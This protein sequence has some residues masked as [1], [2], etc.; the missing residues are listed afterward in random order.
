MIFL[1][2]GKSSP[3]FGKVNVRSISDH[4][5]SRKKVTQQ[6]VLPP[7]S[8][9][10][11]EA[12]PTSWGTRTGGE[13]SGRGRDGMAGG[14][15]STSSA[16]RAKVDEA[17][18][19]EEVVCFRL[20][21]ELWQKIVDEN[22]Q[23]NDLLALAMTCRLFRDTTKVLGRK[24]ETN[25]K[26]NR[27][28]DLQ[29][30]GK[31]ASHTLD[32]FQWVC[33]TFEIL[34]GY[35]SRYG[36]DHNGRVKGAVYEGDLV[37][38]AAFQGS[39]EILRWLVE[40]KGWEPNKHT[41]DRAGMG[42]S[43]KV[44]EYVKGK[45]YELNGAACAGAARGG[46]LEALK[47]LR[48]QDPPCPWDEVT[49][50]GA[51]EGGHLEVL[52]WSRSQDPPCPWDEETCSWAAR[53]GHLD[54][55]KWARDQDP[56]CPWDEVTCAGA[57]EGGHLEVLKW[58]RSQDPPCPW[59]DLT[60]SEAAYGGHLDVL[61]WAR[62]QNP[63]CPWYVGT[64]ADAAYGG[65]LHILKWA[66]SENPPCPWSGRTCYDAAC[67]GH[68][69]I[70]KWARAQDLPCPWSRSECREQASIF[71][72]QHVIDWIDQQ[73]DESDGGSVDFSDTLM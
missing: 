44:L 38:C 2:W 19:E 72:H 43:V 32:W 12:T 41:C 60:C 59:S 63:P 47:F 33:D 54:V 51:A 22:L 13:A 65:Q 9:D 16:K 46:R 23:Q 4:D 52:K 58:A 8:D 14:A 15:E 21:P 48:S 29:E 45:G 56:P 69:H 35:P 67:G 42:G 66:R 18:D 40:E 17:K 20:P 36:W 30:I 64:C 3:F 34:P 37:N 70:L 68:L 27:L 61:K 62:A 55:L 53:N 50:A 25:L 31:V 1:A 28:L 57:A 26:K 5:R 11:R 7:S 10:T 73:E 71:E 6:D 24:L 39:V 49:C